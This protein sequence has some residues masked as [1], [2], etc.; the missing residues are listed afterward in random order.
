MPLFFWLP[1]ILMS[2]MFAGD[3]DHRKPPIEN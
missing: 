3:P 2:A 1:Y